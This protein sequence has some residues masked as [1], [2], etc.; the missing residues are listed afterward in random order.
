MIGINAL[1]LFLILFVS[2]SRALSQISKNLEPI[3]MKSLR[4]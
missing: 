2:K 4:L 1:F 3:F